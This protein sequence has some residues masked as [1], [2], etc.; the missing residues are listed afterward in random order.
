M[1]KIISLCILAAS[2]SFGADYSQMSTQE[3]QNMRGSVPIEDREAFRTEMQNR[4]KN[5]SQEERESF[6][7]D[8]SK[9]GRGQGPR[10]GS[11]GGKG[12]R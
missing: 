6:M 2:L 10:D 1:K 11:G 7:K 12:R 3:M 8:G 5:M 9:R 4:M